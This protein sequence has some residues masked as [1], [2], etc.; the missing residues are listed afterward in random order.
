ME[1][2]A[3]DGS[4]VLHQL[5]LLT[6]GSS[7]A[8][9]ISRR[10]IRHRPNFRNTACGRPQRWQ[11]V[12][13]RTANFGLRAALLTRAFLAISVVSCPGSAGRRDDGLAGEGE[14]ELPEQLA[15]LLVGGGGGDQR[16]V[17]PAR[18]VDLVDVDLAEHR[19]LGQPER[20]VAVAVELLGVQAAEVADAGQ[21]Q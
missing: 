13:P 5:D 21:R 9:A 3:A 10:Q 16:D 12:Y 19:L 14:A 8:C 7:P 20:V 1:Q 11:R 17:H 2:P 4:R 15:T 6:P 18:S